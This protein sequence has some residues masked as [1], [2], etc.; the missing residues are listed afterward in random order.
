MLYEVITQFLG[1]GRHPGLETI[2]FVLMRAIY[3]IIVDSGLRVNSQSVKK[4]GQYFVQF[5]RYRGPRNPAILIGPEWCP[6]NSILI[7]KKIQPLGKTPTQVQE[8][9]LT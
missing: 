3:P 9:A 1:H 8:T 5:V 7:L 2:L 4:A 6:G